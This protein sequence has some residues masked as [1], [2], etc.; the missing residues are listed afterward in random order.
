MAKFAFD[1]AAA[2]APQVAEGTYNANLD[3]IVATL[4][5]DP[6]ATDDGLLLG[7]S[8]SGVGESGLSLSIGR[9]S[10]DKA[11]IGASFTR[12]LSD[13]LA[14]E[15]RT[16]SFSWPWG[17][18][19]KTTTI[20]TPVDADFLPLTGVH[21]LLN[22]VGLQA[23]VWG[24]GV[25]Y[26]IVPDNTVFPFSALVYYFGNRLELLDCRCS[27]LAIKYTPGTIAIATAEIVVG[28]IKD[29]S[30]K[31]ITPVALPTLDYGAQATQSMPTI[32]S[33]G[34]AWNATRGFSDLTLTFAPTIDDIPDSNAVD[35]IVKEPSAMEIGVEATLF[36]DDAGSGETFELSQALSDA[37]GD[38]LP[39]TFTV[40]SA[41]TG[42]QELA[43]GHSVTIADPELDETAME[44]LGSKAAN[45]IKLIARSATANG[46]I[47]I[48]LI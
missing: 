37:I 3:A 10:R 5:G 16:F 7:D 34:N 20:T 18:G 12:S 26:S 19:L 9:R 11:V 39:L 27:S 40:G 14:A 32:E 48:N 38:L 42:A 22:G 45:T 1:V 43:L 41:A 25:G 33:I 6:D 47:E 24:S 2:F 8:G 21:A 35:G 17:G 44:K 29:P 46:E 28:S 13:F 30:S 36:A 23:A 31:V 4:D 15:V